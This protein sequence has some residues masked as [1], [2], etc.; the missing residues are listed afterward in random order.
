LIR[1]LE[2]LTVSRLVKKCP[3]LY[4]IQFLFLNLGLA[5]NPILRQN[6]PYSHDIF[7]EDTFEYYP[8]IYAYV[9]QETSRLQVLRLNFLGMFFFLLMRDT[10]P[11]NLA[12]FVLITLIMFAVLYK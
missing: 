10:C 6:R 3:A 8:L 4:E 5:L 2:K 9:F 1:G 12:F 7:L 11:S